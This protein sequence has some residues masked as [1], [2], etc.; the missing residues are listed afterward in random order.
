MSGSRLGGG[1]SE[2]GGPT[3]TA[4]EQAGQRGV[5]FRLR[6][7]S[8]V[9]GPG[10]VVLISLLERL[11]IVDLDEA[12]PGWAGLPPSELIQRVKHHVLTS[13]AEGPL[14]KLHASLGPPTA[15]PTRQSS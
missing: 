2:G 13:A 10:I 7:F 15:E 3:G 11:L 6:M 1:V 12:L 14:D 4:S 9:A 5:V 8:R